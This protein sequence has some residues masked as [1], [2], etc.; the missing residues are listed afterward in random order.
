MWLEALKKITLIKP[1]ENIR[2]W[3]KES[4]LKKD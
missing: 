1:Q 4:G 2:E 3:S